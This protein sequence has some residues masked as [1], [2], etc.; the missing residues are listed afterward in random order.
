LSSF[1]FTSIVTFYHGLKVVTVRLTTSVDELFALLLSRDVIITQK[2][3][4]ARS[5]VGWQTAHAVYRGSRIRDVDRF[6]CGKRKCRLLSFSSARS[7]AILCRLKIVTVRSTSSI[8][9]LLTLLFIS[10][11]V[12]ADKVSSTRPGVGWQIAHVYRN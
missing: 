1:V 5:G 4:S 7:F 3:P 6:V 9:E 12:I 10:I 8:Y 2:V 11:I